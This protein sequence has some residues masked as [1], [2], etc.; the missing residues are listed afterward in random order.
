M[1]FDKCRRV[2]RV[3]VQLLGECWWVW[4]VLKFL[5]FGHFVWARH[6][7]FV[8]LWKKRYSVTFWV[9]FFSLDGL[10][11]MS[12][13][14]ASSCQ[15]A[16]HMLANL[17]STCQTAWWISASLASS[18][19]FG[20]WSL[21]FFSRWPLANVSKSGKYLQNC[22]ANIGKS[23]TISEKGHFGKWP[24]FG[25]WQVLVFKKFARDWPL[26]SIIPFEFHLNQCMSR[27]K[28]RSNDI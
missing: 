26:L 19:I 11:P 8:K 9:L 20:F 21:P 5:V 14:L 4:R 24:K 18:D 2:R 27:Y 13:S 23:A 6:A 28:Q 1:A 22:L 16:C 17:V 3:I 12:A 10:W 15:T 25:F 7:K